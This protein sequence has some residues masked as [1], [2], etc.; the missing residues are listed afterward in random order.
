MNNK[1]V[2]KALIVKRSAIHG[3]GVFAN[4][5][6]LENE[7]IEQCYSLICSKEESRLIDYYFASDSEDE[8][9]MPLGFGAIYNHSEAPNVR[10]H[11]N[12]DSKLMVFQANRA[13]SKGEELFISYG[14]D[15]FSNRKLPV[16]RL[17]WIMRW[18]RYLRGLP[19]RAFLVISFIYL[20]QLTFS[21]LP[22]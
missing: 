21:Q 11:Y 2:Q 4:Q 8:R 12:P 17:P 15:W 3:Y 5:S 9:I 22:Y 6:F 7:M 20:F 14:S 18:W 10:F 16:K 1:L 13:I 19:F